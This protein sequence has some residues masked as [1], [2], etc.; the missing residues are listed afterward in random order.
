M[1]TGETI[2]I[3]I[4]FM[5]IAGAGIATWTNTVIKIAKLEEKVRIEGIHSRQ[6]QAELKNKLDDI[7]SEM[8]KINEELHR[9]SG[10]KS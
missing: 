2:G 7:F 9:V 10:R 5:G 3:I 8:K 4:G 1:T 6:Q